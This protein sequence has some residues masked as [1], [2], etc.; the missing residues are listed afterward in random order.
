[1]AIFRPLVEDV[2][3]MLFSMI[4]LLQ[5]VANVT[6]VVPTDPRKLHLRKM[7]DVADVTIIPVA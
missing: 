1:M 2:W 3:K 6:P 7:P 5:P 4:Q